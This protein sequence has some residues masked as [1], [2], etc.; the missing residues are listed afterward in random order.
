MNYIVDLQGFKG[1]NNQFICK[2]VAILSPEQLDLNHYIFKTPENLQHRSITSMWI[3]NNHH[4]LRFEDG[5]VE[6]EKLF[7]IFDKIR[8][9]S[10]GGGT[11]FVKG[12]EKVRWVKQLCRCENILVFDLYHLPSL[13]S[14][15][16][17]LQPTCLLSHPNCALQ[18][19][20]KLGAYMSKQELCLRKPFQRCSR[21]EH[22]KPFTT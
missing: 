11:I 15:S 2:E 9:L 7:E 5:D 3:A 19:V 14:S 21:I 1:P 10:L 16:Y 20:L 6:Y 17:S 12:S 22:N 8:L 4:K 13:K 18:N